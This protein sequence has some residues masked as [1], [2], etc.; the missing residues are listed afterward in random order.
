MR[1]EDGRVRRSPKNKEEQVPDLT[2]VNRNAVQLRQ[3]ESERR[4]VAEALRQSE[5]MFRKITE[6]SIVGV[7]LIQDDVFRY[8]NP[9]M[10]EI[11]GYEVSELVDTRGPKD[12]VWPEDWP[13]VQENLRKRI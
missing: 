2:G 5:T 3:L 10:A 12:V 11:C 1:R 7:Y 13:L 8:V 9:K 4:R 6:K